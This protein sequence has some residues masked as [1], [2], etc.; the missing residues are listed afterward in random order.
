MP[1]PTAILYKKNKS[2]TKEYSSQEL[3]V[4]CLIY[5]VCFKVELH[6][7][8]PLFGH[9]GRRGIPCLASYSVWPLPG[10]TGIPVALPCH[11]AGP[12]P[13]ETHSSLKILQD[14]GPRSNASWGYCFG[15]FLLQWRHEI[16]HWPRWGHTG[17]AGNEPPRLES[18]V[19]QVC[20]CRHRHSIA[21]LKFSFAFIRVKDHQVYLGCLLLFLI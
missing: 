6:K 1:N 17:R 9:H 10:C 13:M 19:G 4:W 16:C 5:F 3:K 11:P 21:M 20:S 12:C 7:W 18:L 14:L 15:P 8:M 2:R